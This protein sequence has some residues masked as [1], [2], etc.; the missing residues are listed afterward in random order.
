MS[1]VDDSREI[2]VVELGGVLL[3]A[4]IRAAEED[5]AVREG[6]HGLHAWLGERLAKLEGPC[7]EGGGSAAGETEPGEEGAARSDLPDDLED[8]GPR[9]ERIVRIG[10]FQASSPTLVKATGGDAGDGEG[11]RPAGVSREPAAAHLPPHA[12]NAIDLG[13]IRARALLKSEACRWAVKNRRKGGAGHGGHDPEYADLKR[14]ANSL[15]D[16][17]VFALDHAHPLPADA[18]LEQLACCFEVLARGA[19]VAGHCGGAEAPPGHLLELLAEAQSALRVAL[20]AADQHKDADQFGL[21]DWLRDQTS[22]HRIYLEHHMRMDDPADPAQWYDLRERIDAFDKERTTAEEGR[23]R[24][25]DLLNKL[26][27]HV[28]KLEDA[29]EDERS[30]HWSSMTNV[31]RDWV[32][33][34]LQPSNRDLCDLLLPLID[35]IPDDVDFDPAARRV[36]KAVDELSSQLE[37][38]RPVPARERERTPEVLEAARLLG[39][40]VVV[41][42]GGQARRHASRQL[43]EDLELGEL[44]W[45]PTTPHRSLEPLEREIGRS[46]VALVILA[47]R[48]SD[49]AMGDL[50]AIAD[51][52][53]VPFLR[54]P[55][56]YNPNR[57]AHEIL[58]QVSDRLEA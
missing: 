17:Y 46:D 30:G 49:H 43:E 9:V 22:E 8:D 55:G 48:W 12:S 15:A 33:E 13:L 5:E 38:H 39:G 26:R 57:V 32:G 31:M 29:R 18:D 51:R 14:R 11:V 44:R 1:A 3:S 25:V 45:I 6:L 24:K 7:P 54:L 40:R 2:D 20:E 50:K 41:M 42:I 16:C 58:E 56:G 19:E 53:G 52:A 4:L 35:D 37:N 47:I 36:L 28:G 10:S 21:Y 34:G 23:R 27:Y